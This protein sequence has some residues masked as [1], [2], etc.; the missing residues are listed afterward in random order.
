MFVVGETARAANWGLN[1]Y[2][3]QT[4]PGLAERGV[5]NFAEVH[6]C[7][8]NTEVSV[9]CLFAPVGRRDYDEAR[10]RRSESLLH[11]LVRAGIGVQ[12]VDNQTGCK[13]VCE[14]LPTTTVEELHPV[15]LCEGGRCLDEGLLAGLDERLTRL[16]GQQVLVLHMLGNRAIVQAVTIEPPGP[17]VSQGMAVADAGLPHPGGAGGHRRARPQ[18]PGRVYPLPSIAVVVAGPRRG[19]RHPDAVCGQLV[20]G[21]QKADQHLGRGSQR[22]VKQLVHL[23]SQGEPHRCAGQHG[24]GQRQAH[25]RGHQPRADGRSGLHVFRR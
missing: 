23:M 17:A 24:P 15:G 4:T 8:T 10:I 1:G 12:W 9:P 14:G 5:I 3:R 2:A 13:G 7:G 25:Q 20:R 11:V 6:S 21:R 18:V 19:R 22:V 16:H